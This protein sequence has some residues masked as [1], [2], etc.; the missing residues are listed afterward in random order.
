[1]ALSIDY[2]LMTNRQAIIL[3]KLFG[4]LPRNVISNKVNVVV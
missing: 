4:I 1:M 3:A 2:Y